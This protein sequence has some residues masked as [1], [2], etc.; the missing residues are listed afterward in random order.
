MTRR[1]DECALYGKPS[2]PFPN[3]SSMHEGG[4]PWNPGESI[5]WDCG[6]FRTLAQQEIYDMDKAMEVKS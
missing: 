5:A 6:S 4:W 2:C 3:L 1:C